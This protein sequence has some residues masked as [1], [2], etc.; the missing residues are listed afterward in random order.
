MT[1][2]VRTRK[3]PHGRIEF[4]FHSGGRVRWRALRSCA[5]CF[6]EFFAE[7][8]EIKR[9]SGNCCS[10]AC[11]GRALTA[12]LG[13]HAALKSD[14]P[15]WKGETYAEYVDGGGTLP[16]NI[17]AR[18]RLN[19]AVRAGWIKREICVECHTDG[20]TEAHHKDYDKPYD[21]DW[22][23]PPCHREITYGKSDL[24]DVF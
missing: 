15:N 20:H 9:G 23:C 19:N 6:N 10:R 3:G 5:V 16:K 1:D 8:Y 18:S 11:Q 7:S 14:N 21:V 4:G 12:N 24:G 2:V 22:V 13:L 17:W